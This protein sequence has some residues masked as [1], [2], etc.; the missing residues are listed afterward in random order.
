MRENW[1]YALLA[2]LLAAISWY[3]VSGREKVDTWLELPV[4]LTG[5]PG[6]MV[7]R[8]G[9]D[10]SI[11]VRVRGPRGLFSAAEL[12]STAYSLDLSNIKKGVNVVAID[13]ESV[14]LSGPFE[15]V[16]VTPSRMQLHVDRIVKK[17]VPVV[18]VWSGEVGEDI[19]LE[20]SK[21]TPDTVQ[22][23]GPEDVVKD[24]VNVS[25]Q[26]LVVDASQA[27]TVA[28]AAML[29][30]PDAVEVE[31]GQVEVEFVFSVKRLVTTITVPVQVAAPEGWKVAVKPRTVALEVDMPVHLS[32]QEGLLEQ[33][34]ALVVVRPPVA[35][36][37]MNMRYRL[38]L[39][40]GVFRVAVQPETISVTVRK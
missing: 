22:V 36:G 31:P 38:Q 17:I 3:W 2:V 12:K 33:F 23:R 21:V 15:V 19:R 4:E 20:E 40:G 29:N 10:K 1:Q 37:E 35:A 34:G 14:P 7:I 16:E 8:Q 28:S 9:L 18:V 25:T 24:V 27:V 6:D 11:A 30:V 13:P 26:E 39:P 5:M 32:R